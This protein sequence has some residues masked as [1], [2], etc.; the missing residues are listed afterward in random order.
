MVYTISMRAI[1]LYRPKSEHARSVEEFLHIFE[2]T[3][4]DQTITLI[5]MDTIEGNQLMEL[6][7]VMEFPAV[8]VL[9]GDGAILNSW[10]GLP[11][12]LAD[13]VVG[14]LRV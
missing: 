7:D 1:I 4:P 3:Y 2:D 8:L 10:V 6:Y 5:D 12:P 11:L 9:A 13:D 14:Y